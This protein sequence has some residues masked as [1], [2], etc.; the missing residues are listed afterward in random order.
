MKN[1]YEI[2]SPAGNFESL[3]SGINAGCNAIYLGGEKFS[4]RSKAINFSD[5]ELIKAVNYAHLRNVRIFV[6]I[7]ILIDDE[8][9]QDA[10]EFTEFLY[11]IGVDAIIVQDIGF[12]TIA[13]GLF[14][15]MEIHASTQMA[16]NNLYGAKFVEGLGFERVVLAREIG[17]AHV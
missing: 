9:M 15:K 5:E 1:N 6:A 8:E 12:A 14:P 3:V 7:N 13:R 17:R 4:A 2:L 16:I 11:K 10:L